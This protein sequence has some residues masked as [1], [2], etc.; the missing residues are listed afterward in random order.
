MSG[1]ETI[2]LLFLSPLAVR[3]KRRFVPPP[4][5]IYRLLREF[6]KT[7]SISVFFFVIYTLGSLLVMYVRPFIILALY[8]FFK[9]TLP[10]I[11][12]KK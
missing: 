1:T 4:I 7:R 8:L 2:I 10:D 5:E 9:D 11:S 6:G 12:G 3:V